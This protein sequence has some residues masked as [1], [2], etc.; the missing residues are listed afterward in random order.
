M[1]E[2]ISNFN[3]KKV[4]DLLSDL[5]RNM[6]PPDSTQ[7]QLSQLAIQV[8]LVDKLSDAIDEASECS[9]TES[10]ALRESMGGI[11]SSLHKF[12]ES[13]EKASRALTRATYALAGVLA[14]VALIQATIFALQWLKIKG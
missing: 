5:N 13:N 8:Q 12:R 3:Q 10:R 4:H 7:F 2:A 9:A 14:G 6:H 1:T 11:R